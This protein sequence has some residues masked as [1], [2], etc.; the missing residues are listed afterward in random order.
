MTNATNNPMIQFTSA[1]YPAQPGD[2]FEFWFTFHGDRGGGMAS[3]VF[4]AAFDATLTRLNQL[5]SATDRDMKFTGDPEFLVLTCTNK[6]RNRTG[7]NEALGKSFQGALINLVRMTDPG[8]ATHGALLERDLK[9]VGE[10]LAESINGALPDMLKE[11]EVPMRIVDRLN[12]DDD[13]ARDMALAILSQAVSNVIPAIVPEAE[14]P[15][16]LSSRLSRWISS[17][18]D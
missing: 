9:H 4:T 14:G 5:V 13:E 2:E 17:R 12:S 18:C 15:C 7:K 10:I 16:W 6:R 11:A 3:P 1:E 8:F